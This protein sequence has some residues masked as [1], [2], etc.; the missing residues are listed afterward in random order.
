MASTAASGAAVVFDDVWF[1]YNTADS[2]PRPVLAGVS[3]ELPEGSLTLVVGPT[4][5][6]KSTLLRAINGLVPRHSGGTLIGSITTAGH[7]T[8]M[9]TPRELARLVGYCPQVPRSTF[10]ADTVE[11][12]LAWSMEQLGVPRAE[13]RRRVEETLDLLRLH[14]LRDRHP[15]SLS[16]GEQQR[17][18]LGATL[19]TRPSVLVLDEPTSALD[20]LGAE[21]MIAALTRLVWDLGVTVVCAEHRI[22]RIAQHA[23]LVVELR[24]DGT[25]RSGPPGEILRSGAIAPPLAQLAA[26][27]G[28]ATTPLA[29]RDARALA[30]PLRATLA[31]R[32][33]ADTSASE[34]PVGLSSASTGPAD[35]AVS[36]RQVT[37]RYP[38][39][40]PEALPALDRVDLDIPPGQIIALMGRNGSG[41][42]TLL[43]AAAGA[44]E[45]TSGTAR[46]AGV[47]PLTIA[48][49]QRIQTVGWVPAEPLH[50]L[51]E[52]T[53]AAELAESDRHIGAK[54][55]ATA[56][57]LDSLVTIADRS[58]HPRD[59]SAGQRLALALAVV[60]APQP[61]VL[62]LDEP[63]E[64]LDQHACAA[65][66]EWLVA[67]RSEG[68]TIALA[69]HD[70]EFVAAHADRVVVMAQ[71]SIIS[72][73]SP[74]ASFASSSVFTTQVGRVMH[75]FPI[76]TI[77]QLAQCL[78]SVTAATSQSSVP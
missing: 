66:G 61:N 3:L 42:S 6:G 47:D 52:T 18:A 51:S 17:V 43:Q 41:K 20:P 15:G 64:G 7:A 39:Q 31:D 40:R 53:V 63:T 50:L 13:M 14:P 22:E 21:E 71:G 60:L 23:D 8:R 49:K 73:D 45:P 26:R 28:W 2:S 65:L 75:P 77:D 4:G 25:A 59:L 74:T 56:A 33:P 78:P 44:I 9:T 5:S 70:V 27:L 38:G 32:P 35:A 16:S 29:V 37:V 58:T 30:A 46:V 76:I 69:T 72:D 12:E 54:V 68:T 36:L 1:R 34:R 62:L 67:H 55:G 24:P 57:L 10:V 19:G 48:P 11:A